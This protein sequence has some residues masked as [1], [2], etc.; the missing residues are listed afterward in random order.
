MP[1]F[2]EDPTYDG[3]VADLLQLIYA[4]V[5]RRGGIYKLHAD[6]ANQPQTGGAKV[7]DYLWVGENVTNADTLRE[8]TKDHPPYVVPCIDS[9]FASIESDDEPFLSRRFLTCSSR[10]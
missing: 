1:A 4:E 5:T 6:Y 10:C 3:A 8:A 7:Y 2:D 9:S